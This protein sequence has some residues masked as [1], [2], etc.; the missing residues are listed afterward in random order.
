MVRLLR[1]LLSAAML[2]TASFQSHNGAIAAKDGMRNGFKER[3]FNP[4][5]VRLLQNFFPQDFAHVNGF[6]PTMVRL[7][8]KQSRRYLRAE[9]GFQ[10]HN[11]AI[12]AK[13]KFWVLGAE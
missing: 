3:C 4:T 2:I 9:T 13:A 6:N 12:A 10:S 8:P 7:L 11:G 1:G 5:M